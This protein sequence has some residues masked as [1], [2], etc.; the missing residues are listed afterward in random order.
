MEAV[1]EKQATPES[2]KGV[3]RR[4]GVSV[5]AIRYHCPDLAELIVRR[6]TAFQQAAIAQKRFQARA[7]VKRAIREWPATGLP[8]TKKALLRHLFPAAGLPK[9]LIRAEIQAQWGSP[10]LH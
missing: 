4:I 3:A 7:A 5:G 2:L 1:I 6:K 10:H 8:M 9:N